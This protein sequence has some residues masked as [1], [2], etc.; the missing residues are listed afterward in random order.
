MKMKLLNYSAVL[1]CLSVSKW[2]MA[3][4]TLSA[5]WIERLRWGGIG[6]AEISQEQRQHHAL[7]PMLH[8]I[9][10][11]QAVPAV[12]THIITAADTNSIVGVDNLCSRTC[13]NQRVNASAGGNWTTPGSIS[14]CLQSHISFFEHIIS[15]L[16]NFATK[17]ALT[18]SIHSDSGDR[19]FLSC[20]EELR[21]VRHI[22]SHIINIVRP[23][24][25]PSD[26]VRDPLW[27][28]NVAA[29]AFHSAIRALSDVVA[30]FPAIAHDEGRCNGGNG[31]MLPLTPRGPAA[32]LGPALIS[33]AP[34][35]AAMLERCLRYAGT[36]QKAF[37]SLLADA[38]PTKALHHIGELSD[39]MSSWDSDLDSVHELDP[40]SYLSVARLLSLNAVAAVLLGQE[41]K[42]LISPAL[43]FSH[44]AMA[45][46]RRQGIGRAGNET[47]GRDTVAEVEH[48]YGLASSAIQETCNGLLTDD[49]SRNA[50]YVLS[51]DILARCC[52]AV[53]TILRET[54]PPIRDS[55]GAVDWQSRPTISFDQARAISSAL[56]TSGAVSSAVEIVLSTLFNDRYHGIAIE[57]DISQAQDLYGTCNSPA[58]KAM[59]RLVNYLPHLSPEMLSSSRYFSL[60][61]STLLEIAV[62]LVLSDDPS[63]P[64]RSFV[65]CWA[66]EAASLR[67]L[68]ITGLN[69]LIRVCSNRDQTGTTIFA[70]CASSIDD[71]A[72]AT[73]GRMLDDAG[74]EATDRN[75]EWASDYA[76]TVHSAV[77]TRG[78]FLLAYHGNSL[79]QSEKDDGVH[80]GDIPAAY[81]RLL[82]LLGPVEHESAPL[83]RSDSPELGPM[84]SRP[85]MQMSPAG[86]EVIR[87]GFISSFFHDHSIGRL[88]QHIIG[89]LG[90][91]YRCTN[92]Y[93]SHE[94]S[95]G[96]CLHISVIHLKPSGVLSPT[97]EVQRR[98]EAAADD[99]V[100]V[101]YHANRALAKLGQLQ[102]DVLVF[103][104]LY[105]DPMVTYVASFRSSP[106]QIAFWGHPYTSGQASM[107]YFISSVD[108]EPALWEMA[109]DRDRRGRQFSEQIVIFESV[110]AATGASLAQTQLRRLNAFNLDE[111]LHASQEEH[112][113]MLSFSAAHKKAVE[114]IL[115]SKSSDIFGS[116]PYNPIL[117]VQ[118][119]CTGPRNESVS[120][121]INHE[122]WC[123]ATD[124]RSK[125]EAGTRSM[126]WWF[127]NYFTARV[128]CL[129]M[130]MKMHP[131]VDDIVIEVR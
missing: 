66:H 121:L 105:M 57:E 14:D 42:S 110:G 102:L 41:T 117:H 83:P 11:N 12:F 81:F 86:A 60:M 76:M 89:G 36:Y 126:Y 71:P 46:L 49:R 13:C 9:L 63:L 2:E 5:Q 98:I 44:S 31:C 19:Y 88:F 20:I 129:Q 38:D 53:K 122:S 114:N 120:K 69:E 118:H 70:G 67:V 96:R 64:S 95:R 65:P 50:D 91:K 99:V 40:S 22:F 62:P 79:I 72:Y 109:S 113:K 104:D 43:L 127:E 33:T 115:L 130:L 107:D 1:T 4:E 103:T 84:T 92:S 24:E 80:D 87:V 68:A 18:N 77:G 75:G 45:A 73:H 15:A 123:E 112:S 56:L 74:I 101:P 21:V 55:G 106:V 47:R 82:R 6:A 37:S 32:C 108:Y 94:K 124:E 54:K 48:I 34:P 28:D 116:K 131:L 29:D 61:L 51:S 125:L 78:L 52:D 17:K 119:W 59:K 30:V 23:D 10:Y 26:I 3:W 128:G 97:G 25:I 85:F 8:D 7:S 93:A 16:D 35:A 39:L 90:E 100:R 111:K 27:G 58:L